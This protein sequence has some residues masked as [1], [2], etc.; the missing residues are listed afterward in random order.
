MK[1]RAGADM[2]VPFGHRQGVDD[3]LVRRWSA[4]C[5]PTTIRVA[6]SMTV[7]RYS[8]PCAVLR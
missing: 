4:V 8:Q 6:R 7:A 5:Q 3:Q 2:P 1:Y